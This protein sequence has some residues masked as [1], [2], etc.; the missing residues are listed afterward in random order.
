MLQRIRHH[1][2]HRKSK[3]YMLYNRMF[4]NGKNMTMKHKYYNDNK[5]EFVIRKQRFC[6]GIDENTSTSASTSASTPTSTSLSTS[7]YTFTP[8]STTNKLSKQHKNK[9]VVFDK[10]FKCPIDDCDYK[11]SSQAGLDRHLPQHDPSRKYVC[12]YCNLRFR[13]KSTLTRHMRT[14]TGEKPYK[15][16]Y[17]NCDY[18]C[19]T[20][21]ALTVHMRTHTGEK[22]YKCD[23]PGCDYAA[24]QKGS[25]KVHQRKHL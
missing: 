12:S 9:K 5:I 6:N 19:T 23:F 20:S 4:N 7:T 15:C 8:I 1:L 10:P 22:P 11:F 25:L 21:G 16:T 14:H 18:E 3:D 17:D 2:M 24:A 13:I